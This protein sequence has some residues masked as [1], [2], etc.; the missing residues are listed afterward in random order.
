[1]FERDYLMKLLAQFFLAIANSMRRRVEEHDPEGAAELLEAAIGEATDFD[2]A[3]LLSLS[4]GSIA[5]VMQV[6]GADPSVMEYVGRGLLLASRYREE[7]GD[8]SLS[9]L[10]AKQA[11]A[12]AQAY[13]F[14]ISDDGVD[15]LLQ[16]A[17]GSE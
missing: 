11:Y 13:G 8:T 10:R 4:P 3:V 7:A 12:L 16:E 9:E 2:A 6:S 17:V 14:D 5:S 15:A 1:M